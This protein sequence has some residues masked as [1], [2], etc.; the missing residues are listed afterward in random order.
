MRLPTT[1]GTM[2]LDIEIISFVQ[3]TAPLALVSIETTMYYI[4][5]W[6]WP[7]AC[8]STHNNNNNNVTNGAFNKK[9]IA[10][11]QRG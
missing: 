1:Y 6:G 7:A 5:G 9:S 4:M 3:K 10:F 2:V 11:V 8:S